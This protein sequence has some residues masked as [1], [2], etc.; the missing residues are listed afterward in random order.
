MG[1]VARTGY[2]ADETIVTPATAEQLHVTWSTH[3]DP[4]GSPSSAMIFSQ[5]IVA[6]DLG[7]VFWG[8]FNGFEYATDIDTGAEVWRTELGQTTDTGASR[9][10]SA[11]SVRPPTR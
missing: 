9:R 3:A 11:W 5:P 4:G 6:A 8:S 1:G 7:L 2:N 10:P